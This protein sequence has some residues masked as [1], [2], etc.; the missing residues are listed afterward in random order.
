VTTLRF[1]KLA[2][3][4]LIPL[5]G[6]L[7]AYQFTGQSREIVVPF[8]PF[9][10]PT[11]FVRSP[12]GNVASSKLEKVDAKLMVVNFWAT[13][14]PPCVEEFPAMLELQRLLEPHGVEII[15]VSIDERWED[16]EAFQKLHNVQVKAGNLVW[17]PERKV[18]TA[19]GSERFPETYVVRPDG[20]V[21]ERIVGAQQ[22]TRPVVLGYFEDLAKKFAG[23]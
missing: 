20:W 5:L 14:C 18:A 13:W 17:D 7:Y 3:M 23:L 21:V 6:F 9:L 2:V 15:F 1:S 19:W 22:W 16:V 10:A 12:G 4:L 11:E 8:K